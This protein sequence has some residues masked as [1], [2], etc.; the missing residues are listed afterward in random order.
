ML[1]IINGAPGTGKT[2]LSAKLATDLELPC[3]NKDS[4]KEFLGDK[5]GVRDIKWS[6]DLGA[7]VAEMLFAFVDMWVGQRG[8]SLIA[9][10][11]YFAQFAVPRIGALV[12]NKDIVFLEIHC[13]T[14][15]EVRRQR[16]IDRIARGERHPIHHGG[17]N[18]L[19]QPDVDIDERY[20]PLRVGKLFEIDTTTFG[21][22]EYQELVSRVQA[23]I[24][25]HQKGVKSELQKA[26]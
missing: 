7:A 24:N 2:T 26:N 5:L 18:T 11:A 19:I 3:L 22:A 10:S 20:A 4:I 17:D 12:E 25:T 14:V 16:F 21:D 15:S 6:Q 23:F 13:S 8:R 1:I 9:E